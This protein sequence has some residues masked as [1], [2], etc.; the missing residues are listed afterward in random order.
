[1]AMMNNSNQVSIQYADDKNLSVRLNLHKKHAISKIPVG[2]WFFSHYAIDKPCRI[3]ELGC[4]NANQWID[5]VG[6]LPNGTTLILSDFS[7]G[8]VDIAWSRLKENKNVF[9]QRIDIQDIPFADKSFDIVIANH[10]LYHVPNIKTALREVK[11]VLADDGTF[12]SATNGSNGMRAY[13]HKELNKFDPKIDAFSE[14]LSFNLQNGRQILQEFFAEI[15]TVKYEDS[16][17]VTE[18][19]DLID[20]IKSTISVTSTEDSEFDG[21][22]D[23]FENIRIREGAINIPKEMGMFISK[24]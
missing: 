18:T 15:N 10:M 11:R 24:K 13:L 23:H 17:R 8:M 14:L 4:G 5:R 3:L 20:W 16:L 1:M 22:F 9:V 7:N 21:L 19:M 6:N 2:D 12:F